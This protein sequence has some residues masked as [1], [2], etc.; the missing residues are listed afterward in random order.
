MSRWPTPIL[1]RVTIIV[2]FGFVAVMFYGIAL[3]PH[4]PL[5]RDGGAIVDKLGRPETIERYRHFRIWERS[6]IV[7]GGVMAVSYLAAG[8]DRY[9]RTGSFLWRKS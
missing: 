4:A 6:L 5:R 7:A 2:F 9:R 1:D 8:I 3:F